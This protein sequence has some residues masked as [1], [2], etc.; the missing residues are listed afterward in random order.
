[1]VGEV[2]FCFN[3]KKQS[4]FSRK[5]LTLPQKIKEELFSLIIIGSD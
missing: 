5:I 3:G 2:G 4:F 1:M